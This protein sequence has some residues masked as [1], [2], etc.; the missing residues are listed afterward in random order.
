MLLTT[1]CFHQFHI[2][3]FK[4]YLKVRLI[5]AKPSKDPSKIDFEEPIC[6]KCKKRIGQD[7]INECLTKQEQDEIEAKQMEI[8]VEQD[9]KL[10]KCVECNSIISFEASRPNY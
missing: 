9:P 7:D 5:E 4:D 6:L 1:E 3:C 8:R 10:F 2:P